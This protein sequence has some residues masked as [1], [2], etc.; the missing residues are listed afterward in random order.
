MQD[1]LFQLERNKMMESVESVIQQG[2]RLEIL[3]KEAE[4]KD[5]QL[6][7]NKYWTWTLVALSIL[8]LLIALISFLF[9]RQNKLKSEREK[10]K[11]EQE[12]IQLEQTLLRTQ[13]NPHF[14]ANS[15]AAIQ[16]N[17]Y[18]QDK[19]KSVTYLSKFAKLMRFILESSREKEVLLEKEVI[20]LRNYMDLQ[21]LLLEEK[22][23][24]T[25][26]VE[27]GFHTDEYKIPPMLI[28]PFVENAIVHGVELKTEPGNVTLNFRK[29]KELLKVIIKDDGLGRERVNEIYKK[30]NSNHM[31][32][33]TNITNERIEK[34]NT[35]STENIS[36]VTQDIVE[37]GEVIGTIVE[38]IIPLKSVY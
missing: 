34:I 27:D 6:Q 16:G 2:D 8:F 21:K 13:M 3:K 33:S 38:L 35:E 31:S 36:S 29:E 4:I 37:N 9:Y 30:R 18:K 7:Q 14:I 20:S 22:L 28:Q 10:L 17:I 5:L 23:T 12:S 19:E 11:L 15:L 26:D 24:Y 32:F 1:S 25:I